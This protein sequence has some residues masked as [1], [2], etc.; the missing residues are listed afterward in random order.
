M[1]LDLCNKRNDVTLRQ[2]LAKVPPGLLGMK[3]LV[4]NF[5]C[6][7]G[8]LHTSFTNP[9]TILSS[10]S[11]RNR[12]HFP[13]DKAV[14]AS[15][16]FPR[17][18][19]SFHVPSLHQVSPTHAWSEF[20]GKMMQRILEFCLCPSAEK[21]EIVLTTPQVPFK[22]KFSSWS[23]PFHSSSSGSKHCCSPLG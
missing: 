1:A 13:R 9:R 15:S 3:A 20:V 21:C 2:G 4:G 12:P 11:A 14:F 5:Q 23:A 8:G 18:P 10:I 22:C 19:P 16:P 6:S 17:P 7:T